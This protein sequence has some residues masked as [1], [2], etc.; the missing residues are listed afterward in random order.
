MTDPIK[1]SLRARFERWLDDALDNP[2]SGGAALPDELDP[3]P[4]AGTDLFALW[5]AMTAVRQEVALQGRAFARLTRALEDRDDDAPAPQANDAATLAALLDARERLRRSL[6]LPPRVGPL[7][8][9]LGA[10]RAVEALL[11]GQRLSLAALDEQLGSLGVRPLAAVGDA[12]DPQTMQ[13]IAVDAAS[14]Q[15]E[16]TVLEVIAQGYQRHGSTVRTAHVRLAGK[17]SP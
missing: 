13:A 4:P 9:W 17:E 1:A 10:G 12:F 5:E 8:R 6:A 2:P 3:A 15:P 7:A 11:E 14:G 16:G